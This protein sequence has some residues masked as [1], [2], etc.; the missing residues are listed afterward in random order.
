MMVF[1][2]GPSP[3][4]VGASIYEIKTASHLN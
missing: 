1:V 4:H 3:R 2:L